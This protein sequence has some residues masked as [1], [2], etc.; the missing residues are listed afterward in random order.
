MVACQEV[1]KMHRNATV[2]AI[3][4]L[5]SLFISQGCQTGSRTGPIIPDTGLT[6]GGNHG[7]VSRSNSHVCWG[8]WDVIID[9][10]TLEAE[11]TPIRGIQWHANVV[12]FLDPPKHHNLKIVVDPTESD[13]ANGFFVVY[14]TLTHPF[15]GLNQFRGFDVRGGFFSNGTYASA[16]DPSG[17]FPNPDPAANESRLLNPDGYMRWFNAQEF[18]T[19]PKLLE[20]TPTKLGTDQTTDSTLNPYKYFSD[21]FDIP[22]NEDLPLQAVDIDVSNRGQFSP[23]ALI[24]R[25]YDIQFEMNGT[26]PVFAFSYAVDASY[27]DP[28]MADPSFPLDAFPISANT[29]EAYKIVSIDNGSTAFYVDNTLNGG[30]LRFDLELYDW[31]AQYSPSG[32]LD[33]V[34]KIIVESPTLFGNY[35]GGMIDVTDQFDLNAVPSTVTSSVATIE[36]TDVTPTAIDNQYVFFTV[37]SAAPSDYSNPWGAPYPSAP[38]LSSYY[39][40]T[41]PISDYMPPQVGPITGDATPD[42]TNTAEVYTCNVANWTPSLNYT[43]IWSLE[44]DGDP[45]NYIINTGSNNTLT[46][47]WCTYIPGLYDMQVQVFDGMEYG[48]SPILDITRGLSACTGTAH[49][50]NGNQPEWPRFSYLFSP[51]VNYPQGFNYLPRFDID[52]FSG[53]DFDGQG[54]LQSSNNL[55]MNFVV[56]GTGFA[57]PANITQWRIPGQ[58]F[59]D[60]DETPPNLI[61]TSPRVVTSLDTS[62]DIDDTDGYTDNRI[63][64]V[65][66]HHHGNIY[67]IDADEPLIP[68]QLL[69]TLT[70]VNGVREI[71]CAAI[72]EDDDIWALVM[73]ASNQYE[74]HLQ[75]P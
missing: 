23:G 38:V 3:V 26:V 7:A 44:F 31:Q 58:T 17:I 2:A 51:P 1:S 4:I 43:Y 40:W 20:Y 61:P 71:R 41:A 68:D 34:G 67:I 50:Y 18:N 72:D 39:L 6:L 69:A 5:L 52:F 49:T 10:V 24:T 75:L 35:A 22:G 60:I 70:D 29:Q 27:S 56:T 66:S 42:E 73:S 33:E 59:W 37:E 54:I 30:S 25:R 8:T 28:D 62:P 19:V 21:D 65:T 36:I 14:V 16:Y 12:Q 13:T 45:V 64:I 48:E 47:D 57:D 46:I 63:V 15:P 11:I 32:V 9:P 55:L 53:G 74:L